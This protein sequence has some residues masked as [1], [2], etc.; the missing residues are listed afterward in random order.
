MRNRQ[1]RVILAKLGLDGHDRGIKVVARILR[2]AG[3]EVI[4]LGL[5]QTTGSIVAAAEEEDADAIGL[6]MHNA[7]HLTLGPKMTDA[8]QEAGLDIPLVIGGIVPDEDVE[9]LINSG[10]AAVLGPGASA[11]EVVS[12][13]SAAISARDQ[14]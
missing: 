5:R 14:A 4:Y 7:G 13:V 6:S 2:D 3:M 11:E 10:V 9:E 8:L 12:T 1:Y